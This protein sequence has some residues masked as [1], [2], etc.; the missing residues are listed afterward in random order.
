MQ[1]K[2][3]I[4]DNFE[5]LEEDSTQT[6][7][8]ENLQAKKVEDFFEKTDL[9]NIT[10]SVSKNFQVD[11]Y[12]IPQKRDDTLFYVKK[13]KEEEYF[14]LYMGSDINSVD[15]FCIFDSSLQ[16]KKFNDFSVSPNGVYVA[17]YITEDQK[18]MGGISIYDVKNKAFLND[19]I[20]QCRGL[21]IAW[22]P[23][24]SGLYY[25]G[26]PK[27]GGDYYNQKIFSHH[28]G[29]IEKDDKVIFGDETLALYVFAVRVNDEHTKLLITG[30]K[31]LGVSNKVWL[32]DITSGTSQ[33]LFTD[34]EAFWN[35]SFVGEYV[36]TLTTQDA[37]RR[38]ILYTPLETISSEYKDWSVFLSEHVEYKISF[39]YV[40]KDYILVVY[41]NSF[42]ESFLLQKKIQSNSNDKETYISL[43]YPSCV[44]HSIAVV[45]K[46]KSNSFYFDCMNWIIPKQI[47]FFDAENKKYSLVI[48]QKNSMEGMEMTFSKK[49]AVDSDGVRIP[50]TIIHNVNISKP[51][52]CILYVYGGFGSSQ[53]PHFKRSYTYWFSKGYS[54]AIAHVRGGADLGKKWHKDGSGVV[55]V[56]RAFCFAVSEIE[57]R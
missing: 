54:L 10:D 41:T 39:S 9:Y 25:A 35:P 47:F 18:E 37:E 51:V 1:K 32:F 57:E 44:I 7:D 15:E 14:S 33:E 6:L 46:K 48:T 12:S 16:T 13:K 22:F 56:T 31:D 5:W 24:D 42:G 53:V 19:Y 52:P 27:T 17:L 11:F 40:L 4:K 20:S 36:F 23:D 45:N 21:H 55:G 29:N 3:N 28:I 2:E 38:Q 43:P 26:Y 49:E 50:L 30:Q 8:W 34:Q